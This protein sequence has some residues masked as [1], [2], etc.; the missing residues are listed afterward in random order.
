MIKI[1]LEEMAEEVDQAIWRGHITHVHSGARRHFQ[2][3][4]IIFDFV[5]PYL[6]ASSVN[7][8]E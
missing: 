3:L 2:D 5:Q 7:N 6:L 1:W 4:D 8:D